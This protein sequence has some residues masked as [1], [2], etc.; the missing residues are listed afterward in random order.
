MYKWISWPG[1][2]YVEGLVKDDKM[3]ESSG[4]KFEKSRKVE[5]KSL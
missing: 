4:N 2:A 3:F 1:I 5:L